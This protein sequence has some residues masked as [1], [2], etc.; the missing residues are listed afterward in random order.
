MERTTNDAS[1]GNRG[2]V[3]LRAGQTHSDALL[4]PWWRWD[5]DAHGWV[6][7]PPLLRERS[8]TSRAG[9]PG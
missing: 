1:K 4:G 3:R 9:D 2:P 8:A 5:G 7:S 6:A